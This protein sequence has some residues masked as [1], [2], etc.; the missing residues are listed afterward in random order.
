[1]R[2]LTN[3]LIVRYLLMLCA[4]FGLFLILV[5][6]IQTYAKSLEAKINVTEMDFLQRIA[7]V[8]EIRSILYKIEVSFHSI[9]TSPIAS[10]ESR[11]QIAIRVDGYIGNILM[12]HT[13]LSEA[14]CIKDLGARNKLLEELP[15]QLF[16]IEPLLQQLIETV[17]LRDKLLTEEDQNLLL[18][19]A[20]K[21][22]LITVQLPPLFEQMHTLVTTLVERSEQ[23][24]LTLSQTNR[25]TK[26][27]YFLIELAVIA[28]CVAL[29]VLFTIMIF[30]QLL[31]LYA[32]LEKQLK[33]DPLTRLPNRYALMEQLQSC[34]KPLLGVVDIDSF[35]TINELYGADAGNEFLIQLSARLKEF[36]QREGL[37]L[38]RTSGD[39]F[40][41]LGTSTNSS[42]DDFI[43]QLLKILE[44]IR[45][46][47]FF[48][49]QIDKEVKVTLTCGVCCVADSSFEKAEK[50]LHRAKLDRLT[51]VIYDE[52]IDNSEYLQENVR[53]IDQIG[54]ALE[55]DAFVPLFQ[56]IVNAQGYPVTFEAL[57]RLKNTNDQGQVEYIQPVCF[58]DLA[59]KVKSYH[60]LSRMMLFKSLQ[61]AKD[62]DLKVSVNL[63]YQD[64]IN[65]VLI[66]DLH[67]LI[68]ALDIGHQLTFEIVETEDLK[69]Y[70]L[71]KDFMDTFRPLGVKLS[72]DDFGS[73]FSN[74]HSVSILRPDYIKIDGSL[75]KNL[76]RDFL[77]WTLV[78][79]I[80]VLARE[81]QI[82]TI[83]E[84][85]HSEA[86]F[87]KAKEL[88]VDLFQGFY[89]SEPVADIPPLDQSLIPT[90][91]SAP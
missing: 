61:H 9:A 6:A 20:R 78:K 12:L 62:H 80:C 37:Q 11:E 69:D 88:G 1:M 23:E 54:A 21:V 4:T 15:E 43:S 48:L 75:I 34:S 85:V 25:E 45:R 57:M 51:L 56:P 58:L 65:Q 67:Q 10:A 16:Q 13:Q 8:K 31:T 46:S 74:F 72:I 39:E 36:A 73:G 64:L 3:R 17:N 83:A 26:L 27:R 29:F 79:S 42:A 52:S 50:A 38:F 89:F 77:S 82:Q 41:L 59:H 33:T 5:F 22:R 71:V 35:R 70:V 81:L 76:D 30:R 53:W 7:Q 84:Y 18:P 55:Q 14:E 47:G 63:S 2:L 28:F 91:A 49:F 90:K 44:E 68:L 19:I 32:R 87:I 40:A 66:E 60:H 86:I 24:M